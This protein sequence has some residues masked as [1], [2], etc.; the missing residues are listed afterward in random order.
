M[1]LKLGVPI[2]IAASLSP[3]PLKIFD[4]KVPELYLVRLQSRVPKFVH[5]KVKGLKQRGCTCLRK[6][7]TIRVMA[8][9]DKEAQQK[10]LT[11][12]RNS[13]AQRNAYLVRWS[14]KFYA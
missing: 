4:D 8:T 6:G 11:R 9:S 12:K 10:A 2:A 7:M 14:R 5:D 13:L 1:K 3:S